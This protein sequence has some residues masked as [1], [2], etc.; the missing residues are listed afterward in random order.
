MLCNLDEQMGMVILKFCKA[1]NTFEF[2]L[3]KG[4]EEEEPPFDFILRSVE[5]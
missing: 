4:K 2:P 1:K 5:L 3:C